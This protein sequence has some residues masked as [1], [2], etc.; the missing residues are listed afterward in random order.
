MPDAHYEGRE[1][2]LQA[3]KDVREKRESVVQKW[4]DISFIHRLLVTDRLM[5]EMDQLNEQYLDLG[6]S[7]GAIAL[8]KGEGGVT[9][10]PRARERFL[11]NNAL[12]YWRILNDGTRQYYC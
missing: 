4:H 12:A 3:Y 9:D 5:S 1:D 6:I 11:E 8:A 7:L 10:I 2:T